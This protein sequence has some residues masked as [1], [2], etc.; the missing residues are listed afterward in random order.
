MNPFDLFEF[1]L[2]RLSFANGPFIARPVAG[3]HFALLAL[4]GALT[5]AYGKRDE[6][7]M[8]REFIV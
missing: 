8:E 5:A 7:S 2:T 3:G 4:D 1:S 6:D